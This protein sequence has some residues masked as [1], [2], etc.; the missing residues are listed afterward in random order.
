M[1]KILL[2]QQLNIATILPE[3][4]NVHCSLKSDS[5]FQTLDERSSLLIAPG[6]SGIRF[7]SFKYSVTIAV[8]NVSVLVT[9]CS[10][11]IVN[12]H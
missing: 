5:S 3:C 7:D 6:Y 4:T 8:F 10:V 12:L 2:K 11:L 1:F 9:F